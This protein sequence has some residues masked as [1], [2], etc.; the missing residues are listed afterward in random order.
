MG[1]G[2]GSRA[3]GKER[4]GGG[5]R[6]DEDILWKETDE[7]LLLAILHVEDEVGEGIWEA[8]AHGEGLFC[9][10]NAD[11]GNADIRA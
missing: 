9:I 1:V 11:S 8:G 10:P 3:R 4:G 7:V 2:E 6:G 5:R